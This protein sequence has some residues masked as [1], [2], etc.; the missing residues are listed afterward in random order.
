[1]KR[2]VRRLCLVA[3]AA[4]LAAGCSDSPSDEVGFA[5]GETPDEVYTDFVT[6]ESDSGVVLWRLTAPRG[7]RFK[8]KRLVVLHQ[9]RVVFYDERG[10]TRT[11]LVSDAGE[12]YEDRRDMLAYGNVVVQSVEQE[13]LE[14]DSLFWD[15]RRRKIFSDSFVKLTR[16]DNVVTGYG[17]ECDAD[18]SSVEIKREHSGV[19]VDEEDD[20][21]E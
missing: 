8:D 11:T 10:E 9:P 12:Y 5:K 6:Q 16:G 7:D 2:F 4:V 17:L 15:N 18:L 13:V 3:A 1:M 19:I 14:T 21:V 20:L